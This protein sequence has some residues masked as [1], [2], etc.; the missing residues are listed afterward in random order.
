ATEAHVL[1][2]M[3][4]EELGAWRWDLPGGAGTYH[5]LFPRAWID[6]DRAGLPIRLVQQQ[7]TPVLPHNY[8]ESSYPVGLFAWSIENPTHEPLRVGL[9][10]SWQALDEDAKGT[11][12]GAHGRL[13]RDGAF[14]GVLLDNGDTSPGQ[15]A[16]VASED[17]G[18]HAT[19]RSRF[20]V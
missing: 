4:P 11:P 14:A 15:F 17:D 18:V 8:R 1:S 3:R 13:M 16:I 10:F 7:L 5:A 19:A 6:Y 9:M 2:T 12:R 20:V